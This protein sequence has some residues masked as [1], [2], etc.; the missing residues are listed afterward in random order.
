MIVS[1]GCKECFNKQADKCY[2]LQLEDILVVSTRIGHRS[3]P[4]LH[5]VQPTNRQVVGETERVSDNYVSDCKKNLQPTKVVFKPQL[6]FLCR[7]LQ[8]TSQL[9]GI[10]SDPTGCFT[11]CKV[12]RMSPFASQCEWGS[13]FEVL[14]SDT[15]RYKSK[16]F[17]V[18]LMYATSSVSC[19]HNKKIDG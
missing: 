18:T 19:E 13:D 16:A 10:V 9:E 3:K 8:V 17:W 5:G 7:E 4:L 11:S 6:I 1:L 15:A 2:S 12:L 14:Q